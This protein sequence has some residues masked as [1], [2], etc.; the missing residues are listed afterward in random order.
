MVSGNVRVAAIVSIG[1]AFPRVGRSRRMAL[2]YGLQPLR[3]RPVKILE[4]HDVF[5]VFEARPTDSHSG[6]LFTSAAAAHGFGSCS[7][8]ERVKFVHTCSLVSDNSAGAS[9][10]GGPPVGMRFI[11]M[12]CA[13]RR[14]ALGAILSLILCELT[15][16]AVR[17]FEY[18]AIV[19]TAR[20]REQRLSKSER[21]MRRVVCFETRSVGRL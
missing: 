20:R 1:D 2:S 14:A 5:A 21:K 6:F 12:C 7:F 17:V 15:A 8:F 18:P 13:L 4:R 3:E 19:A 11:S 10:L 9:S 16:R